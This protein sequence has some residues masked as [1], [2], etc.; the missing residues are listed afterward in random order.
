MCFWFFV[1]FY[2]LTLLP[3]RNWVTQMIYHFIHKSHART[4]LDM[5]NRPHGHSGASQVKTEL[6]HFCLCSKNGPRQFL[7]FQ[8]W[9]PPE[10]WMYS[11][12]RKDTK[13]NLFKVCIILWKW[14]ER[15]I[16]ASKQPKLQH[17]HVAFRCLSFCFA[18]FTEASQNQWDKKPC[19]FHWTLQTILPSS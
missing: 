16:W 9:V 7:I 6:L 12:Q 18:H 19:Q 14:L 8:L 1:C 17:V 3:F 11:F 2:Y 4:Q 15:Y 10:T 5:L 13:K